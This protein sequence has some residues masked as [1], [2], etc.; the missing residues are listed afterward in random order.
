MEFTHVYTYSMSLERG[1]EEVYIQVKTKTWN[2][3]NYMEF[4]LSIN[5]TLIWGLDFSV[6][7]VW[8]D[9]R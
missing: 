3:S 5:L 1:E 7:I 8:S 9:K 6:V 4:E 2:L